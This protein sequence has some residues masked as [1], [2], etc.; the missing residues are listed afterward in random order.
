MISSVSDGQS[1]VTISPTF[2]TGF[3]YLIL[4]AY[5]KMMWLEM[6]LKDLIICSIPQSQCI[7]LGNCGAINISMNMFLFV[8]YTDRQ[9]SMKLFVVWCLFGD[10]V[11]SCFHSVWYLFRFY[12]TTLFVLNCI[13]INPSQKYLKVL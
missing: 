6:L 8:L 11:V 9:C 13:L 7:I 10:D 1:M 4:V 2:S 12:V 5:M 3:I